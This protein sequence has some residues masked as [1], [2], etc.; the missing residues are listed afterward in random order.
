MSVRV[1]QMMTGRAR[2][3]LLAL[4]TLPLLALTEARAET[5]AACQKLALACQKQAG[6]H[7]VMGHQCR[8]QVDA[9]MNRARCEEAFL[10]CMELVELEETTEEACRIQHARCRGEQASQK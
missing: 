3:A 1:A 4:S 2:Q 10:S 6:A 5:M 7:D 9:C 8:R